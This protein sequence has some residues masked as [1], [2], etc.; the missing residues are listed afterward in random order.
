VLGQL[1]GEREHVVGH[2][3]RRAGDAGHLAGVRAD[4]RVDHLP[5]G[6]L[7]EQSRGRFESGAESVLGHYPG[8]VRVVGGDRGLTGKRLVPA[9]PPDQ[10]TEPGPDPVRQLAGGLTGERQPED[11]VGMGVPVGDQPDHPRGH[12]LGLTGSGAR[13]DQDRFDGSRDD[14]GL[15]RSGRVQP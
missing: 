12:R 1:G 7:G 6:G 8:R 9:Q 11:L 3:P 15:L 2:R 14:R 4:Q 10:L 13:D 5:A